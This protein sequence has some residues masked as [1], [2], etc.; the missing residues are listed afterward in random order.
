MSRQPRWFPAAFVGL[1][2]MQVAFAGGLIAVGWRHEGRFPGLT[3]A[4]G[5]LLAGPDQAVKPAIDRLLRS[6]SAAILSRDREGFLR[7]VDP[8]GHRFLTAQ[9]RLFQRVSEVPFSRWDYAI[10]GA[11]P[12]KVRIASFSRLSHR[13]KAPVWSAKVTVSHAF[14][15]APG[16]ELSETSYLTFVHRGTRWYL[17]GDDDLAGFGLH[18]V[19]Q[20]WE[21]GPVVTARRDRVLVLGHLVQ[22]DYVEQVSGI[23]ERATA[24]VGR[25]LGNENSTLVVIVPAG[26]EEARQLLAGSGRRHQ[27]AQQGHLATLSAVTTG[28]DDSGA[29][30]IVLNTQV[31]AG[32][33]DASQETVLRHEAVHAITREPETAAAPMWLSEGVAEYAAYFG[34][35]YARADIAPELARGVRDGQFPAALPGPESFLPTDGDT[36]EAEF[37]ATSAYRQAWSACAVLVSRVGFSV[38]ADIYRHSGDEPDDSDPIWRRT[39]TERLH[40][41]HDE[42][43]R[44]WREQLVDLFDPAMKR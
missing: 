23:A 43:V 4:H 2:V 30:R 7:T 13:Y 14:H 6:R 19:R 5:L 16:A 15:D 39:L 9:D 10:D 12:A 34:R 36:P 31:M 18:T 44:L 38:L 42:F 20:P 35:G 22:Q 26:D 24:A 29:V 21:F 8:R 11:I 40:L 27:A 33:S 17:G 41:S 25:L 28:G 37:S 32:L 1:I 3:S